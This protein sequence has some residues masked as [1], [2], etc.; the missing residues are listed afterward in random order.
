LKFLVDM[1]LTPRWTAFLSDAG[2]AAVHWSAVGRGDA[3]DPIIMSYAR[4]NGYC[5][6]THDLDFGTIL[7]LANWDRPSVVQVRADDTSPEA[8]GPTLVRAL[9]RSEADIEAGALLTVEPAK[10]RVRL[11]P[12]R[13]V[14]DS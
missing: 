11:L 8:I 14:G 5:L 13:S 9:A 2:F 7:A 1:N 4:D 3:A 12:F 10:L 6:L